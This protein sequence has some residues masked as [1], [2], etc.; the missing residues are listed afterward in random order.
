M[1]LKISKQCKYPWSSIECH[2]CCSPA[3]LIRRSRCMWL[4]SRNLQPAS[5]TCRLPSR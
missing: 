1:M 5:W 3:R 2:W 4:T